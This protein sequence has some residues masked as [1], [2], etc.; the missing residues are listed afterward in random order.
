MVSRRVLRKRPLSVSTR[1]KLIERNPTD[2]GYLRSAISSRRIRQT[3]RCLRRRIRSHLTYRRSH[4]RRKRSSSD[5]FQ[6]RRRK[7]DS[8]SSRSRRT[9]KETRSSRY[10]TRGYLLRRTRDWIDEARVLEAGDGGR[11]TSGDETDQ[12]GDGSSQSPK[13]GQDLVSRGYRGVEVDD[14]CVVKGR[15]SS[16]ESRRYSVRQFSIPRRFRCVVFILA[17]KYSIALLSTAS[18]FSGAS[19]LLPFDRTLCQ[20]N[21][22]VLL[23]LASSLFRFRVS[24]ISVALFSYVSISTHSMAISLIS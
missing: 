23:V 19:E 22:S 9:R 12:A 3:V 17:S 24:P 18:S 4:R 2:H 13:S 10:R 20:S 8:S 11:N 14:C 1:L 21:L 7:F 16:V 6:R 15:E 5:T